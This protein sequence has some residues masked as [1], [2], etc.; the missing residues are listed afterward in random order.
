MNIPPALTHSLE[1]FFTCSPLLFLRLYLV[2][3]HC[4]LCSTMA[5]IITGFI[6]KIFDSSN[7]L[8][9]ISFDVCACC[10]CVS[11]RSRMYIHTYSS[12][13]DSFFGGIFGGLPASFFRFSSLLS[14][15]SL[16]VGCPRQP[17]V[18][19]SIGSDFGEG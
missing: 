1:L 9:K 4:W 2:R 7:S 3:S 15:V 17:R 19:I 14:C 10:V 5:E 12:L 18:L 11:L 16:F 13:T 8:I 6:S